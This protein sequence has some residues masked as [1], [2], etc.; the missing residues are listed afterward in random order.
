MTLSLDDQ[1]I[2]QLKQHLDQ[3]PEDAKAWSDLGLLFWN[4][5]GHMVHAGT[6]YEKALDLAPHIPQLKTN[7][8][9]VL[10]E[11]N[12][13]D[14]ARLLLE[15]A[16]EQ[17]GRDPVF[18]NNL[19][20][21]L[22]EMG[23]Y[24]TS[25]ALLMESIVAKPEDPATRYNQ[26]YLQLYERDYAQGFA[27]YES[28]LKVALK[29]PIPPRLWQGEDLTG[30]RFLCI[31]EQGLGDV[32]HM[33]RY[34]EKLKSRYDLTLIAE[35]AS[36]MESL[37]LAQPCIDEVITWQLPSL[38]YSDYDYGLLYLS[39]PARFQETW[40]Q[41]YAPAR[42]IFAPQTRNTNL[43]NQFD[44]AHSKPRIGIVWEGNPGYRRQRFRKLPVN[45]VR[46]L[47]SDTR[48]DWY[49][50]QKGPA[51]AIFSEP[52]PPSGLT[53]L[54]PLLTDWSA[55]SLAL[56]HLDLVI[57]CDTGIV[58]LAGAMGV[59]VWAGLSAVPDW[60]WSHTISTTP[61]YHSLRLFRQTELENWNPVFIAIKEALHDHFSQR[62]R[63]H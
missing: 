45:L 47:V 35:V 7:L 60:R 22:L 55:T 23:E 42:Y 13:L 3:N 37:V 51:E 20:A 32:F 27:N 30:K 5:P 6:C 62:S 61:W 53:P 24:E 46:E 63:P 21:L 16:V 31:A 39:F 19:V 17:S 28:R 14:D 49:S 56:Q 41:L 10:L 34:A 18:I 43:E 2:I 54:G 15:Q 36:G 4:K 11:L 52:D 48:F 57:S 59:P 12:Q 50:L 58:H 8:G 25:R 1:K 33:L 44:P 26:G 38:T 29:R 40:D 9:L